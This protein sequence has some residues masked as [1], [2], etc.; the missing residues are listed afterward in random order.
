MIEARE[1]SPETSEASRAA[2]RQSGRQFPSLRSPCSALAMLRQL[3]LVGLIAALTGCGILPRNAVPPEL[4]AEATIPHMP[5]VRAWAG[6]TEPGHGARSRGLVRP[7]VA[8][9]TSRRRPTGSCITRISRSP[10]AVRTA[11][12]VPDSS[13]AGPPTGK[14]PVFKIVSGVST[15]RADGAVRLPRPVV[16]RDAAPALHDHRRRATSSSCSRSFRSSWPGNRSPTPGPLAALI[17]RYVDAALLAQVAEA[18]RRGRRLYVGTVDLDAQR[19]SCGTWDSSRRAGVRKRSE[20][21]RKV[22]LAS[23]SVPVAFPPVFFDVEADGEAL[24]RDARRRSRGG[25]RLP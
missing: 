11:R 7:G 15:G 16:R 21:F 3:V 24:R 1:R 10:A 19:S 18:H 8:R 13:T 5:D 25:A 20:L 17:D 23:A 14:R 2:A 22:L 4:S 9:R 6:A 12:S